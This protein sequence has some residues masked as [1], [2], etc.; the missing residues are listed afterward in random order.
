[1]VS[2]L[3]PVD[4]LINNAG[5]V[6]GSSILE[7]TDQQIQ[8]MFDV[9]VMSHFW[10]EI[11][12]FSAIHGVDFRCWLPT[13]AG[14]IWRDIFYARIDSLEK[15]NGKT[16]LNVRRSFRQSSGQAQETLG[17]SHA[18]PCWE[19]PAVS[20]FVEILGEQVQHVESG[21]AED[22][23]NDEPNR[24]LDQGYGDQNEKPNPQR[25]VPLHSGDAIDGLFYN[26]VTWAYEILVN[27]SYSCRSV[28][29]LVAQLLA[30][31]PM[32]ILCLLIPQEPSH[33]YVSLP[34]T[35]NSLLVAQLL[36][37]PQIPIPSI[38]STCLPPEAYLRLLQCHAF[39]PVTRT[40]IH[41]CQPPGALKRLLGRS[42]ICHSLSTNSMPFSQVPEPPIRDYQIPKS[43][44]NP[45]T[46][47]SKIL[48]NHACHSIA[49]HSPKANFMPFD[50]CKNHQYEEPNSTG[51]GNH[52]M[53]SRA[54]TRPEK[55]MDV[56]LFRL[57]LQHNGRKFLRTVGSMGLVSSWVLSKSD[58]RSGSRAFYRRKSFGL[59]F[60]RIP[61]ASRRT[62]WKKQCKKAST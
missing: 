44:Q 39:R 10:L 58:G 31:Y 48:L 37:T 62:T 15:K 49:C 12:T 59:F 40:I 3:E 7:V 27:Y 21:E 24:R 8:T 19:R 42:I 9:N 51:P 36:A 16:P 14:E 33:Q 61:Y 56:T 45:K 47:A 28:L 53:V 13:P 4:I 5:I 26:L 25:L 50:Q 57:L 23:Q 60:R 34:K 41:R 55:Q 30:T 1:M 38:P 20:D 29:I 35:S 2:E 22:Q 43:T 52:D 32:P 18:R 54:W 46:E 6:S 11:V 17:S